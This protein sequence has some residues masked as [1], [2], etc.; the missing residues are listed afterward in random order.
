MEKFE[1]KEISGRKWLIDN[2]KAIVVISHGMAEH[3][4]RYDEFATF[5]NSKD[6]GV[7]A[8][9]QLG[10]G[11]HKVNGLNGHWEKNGFYDCVDNIKKLI[12]EIKLTSK[13]PIFL[14]GHSM[15]SFIAQEFIKRYDFGDD[16]KEKIGN[17]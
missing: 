5:L 17:Q 16:Y 15:G 9:N 7:Y 14:F 10:H 6:I 4:E 11:D 8:I 12:D 2:E 3:A 1:F 13:A